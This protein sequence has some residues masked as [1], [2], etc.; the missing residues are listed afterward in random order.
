MPSTKPRK[1]PAGP[2]IIPITT[3]GFP[4]VER[5]VTGPRARKCIHGRSLSPGMSSDK[6]NPSEICAACSFEVPLF[7]TNGRA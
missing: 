2:I 3:A 4:D 6:V 5:L 1:E 7:K